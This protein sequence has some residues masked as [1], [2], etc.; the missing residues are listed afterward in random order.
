MLARL[1]KVRPLRIPDRDHHT[2]IKERIKKWL[3]FPKQY[4]EIEIV[5]LML[6]SQN[7]YHSNQSSLETL[8]LTAH[9][10]RKSSVFTGNFR[11]VC[12]P[13]ADN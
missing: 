9:A 3:Y 11:T 12:V 6:K 5:L 13:S 2:F 4:K 1:E 7:T 8:R 10:R